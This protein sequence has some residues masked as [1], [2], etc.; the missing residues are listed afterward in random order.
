MACAGRGLNARVPVPG[1]A[2]RTRTRLLARCWWLGA[3]RAAAARVCG[4]RNI[5]TSRVTCGHQRHQRRA[6]SS[7]DLESAACRHHL[8]MGHCCERGR[9]HCRDLG[10]DGT[11]MLAGFRC[12]AAEERGFPLSRGERVGLPGWRLLRP[13]QPRSGAPQRAAHRERSARRWPQAHR[14]TGAHRIGVRRLTTLLCSH[15]RAAWHA[16][17]AYAVRHT[18]VA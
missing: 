2:L 10:A 9:K 6:A 13:H 3:A 12:L 16:S 17:V 7:R 1:I 4:A 15:A 14:S 11:R 8:D 5:A 18:S